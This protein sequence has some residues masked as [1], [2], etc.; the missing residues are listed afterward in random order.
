ML[1]QPFEQVPRQ[2]ETVMAGIG[3]FD[4]HYRAQRLRIMI[5]AAMPLHRFA[6]SIFARMS[7][8][9]VPQVMRQTQR[10]GQV[11][12]QTKASRDDPPDLRDLQAMC[13]PRSIMVT[14]RRY[15]NLGFGTQPPK[16]HRMDD[17][18]TIALKLAAWAA[19]AGALLR[20][21]ATSAGFWIGCV[22]RSH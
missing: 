14:L 10:F 12:V 22:W 21:L 16:A 3:A 15:K 20:K 8:R 5:K 2:I 1:G 7:K 13:H 17:A 9:R 18:V 19:R 4:P 11:F 6:Q